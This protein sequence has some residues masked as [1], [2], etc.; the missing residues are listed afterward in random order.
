MGSYCSITLI[1]AKHFFL[2]DFLMASNMR[3]LGSPLLCVVIATFA[4]LGCVAPSSLS[5]DDILSELFEI[6]YL[7]RRLDIHHDRHDDHDHD[8]GIWVQEYVFWVEQIVELTESL[9]YEGASFGVELRS[10]FNLFYDMVA[11]IINRLYQI[12]EDLG[13]D[14]RS[15][16]IKDDLRKVIKDNLR[17]VIERLDKFIIYLGDLAFR[18]L[19][20]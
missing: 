5:S 18:G 2:P 17:K 8:H 13:D 10:Q 9:H 15:Q 12:G 16:W 20:N 19:K 3:F 1:G 6:D 4:F 11:P 14:E 7:V